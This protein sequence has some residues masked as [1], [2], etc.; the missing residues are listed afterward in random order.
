MTVTVLGSFLRHH[1]VS[2]HLSMERVG[3]ALG[4]SEETVRGYENGRIPKIAAVQKYADFFGLSEEWVKNISNLVEKEGHGQPGNLLKRFWA[5]VKKTEGEGCWEWT[6]AIGVHGY[7]NLMVA[8]TPYKLLSS[9]RLSWQ[10][11]FGEIPE[12]V[13]VCHTCDN[14]KCVRPDHLFLGTAKENM[15][16][17]CRKGRTGNTVLNENDVMQMLYMH[18]GGASIKTITQKFTTSYSTVDA[19]VNRRSWKWVVFPQPSD[20]NIQLAF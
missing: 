15:L 10:L 6:G 18:S 11:A 2:R 12:G 13:Y 14:R 16:D 20:D 7:G 3:R 1:R 19:I 4:I 5:K 8:R 17:K 9:H